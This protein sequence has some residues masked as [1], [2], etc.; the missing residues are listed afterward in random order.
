MPWIGCL[1]VMSKAD[2][3]HGWDVAFGV[4]SQPTRI[5]KY[6]DMN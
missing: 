2:I 4:A 6:S 1:T 5:L 3:S